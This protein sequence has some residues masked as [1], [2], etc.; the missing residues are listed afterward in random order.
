MINIPSHITSL[1][2]DAKTITDNVVNE[3]ID[4]AT[5]VGI[6]TDSVALYIWFDGVELDTGGDG[7]AF[8]EDT[9]RIGMSVYAESSDAETEAIELLTNIVNHYI[10]K[11]VGYSDIFIKDIQRVAEEKQTVA[12]YDF[13]LQF[14]VTEDLTT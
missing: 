11:D 2:N 9:Y 14:T 6:H 7:A 1:I 13:T 10:G 8:T 4:Q 3:N 5:A 12:R